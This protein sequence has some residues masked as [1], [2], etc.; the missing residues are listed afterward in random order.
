[1]LINLDGREKRASAKNKPAHLAIPE[2]SEQ[3][4]GIEAYRI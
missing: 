2:A 1:M 4:Q 3:V